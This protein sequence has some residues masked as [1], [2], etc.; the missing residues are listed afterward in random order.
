L[1]IVGKGAAYAQAENELTQLVNRLKIP[2][3][4]TPMGK[5]KFQVF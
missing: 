5:N 2:F 3:L 4:P 1:F